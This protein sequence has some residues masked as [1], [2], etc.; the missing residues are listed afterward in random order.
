MDADAVRLEPPGAQDRRH[1]AEGHQVAVGE[2]GEAEHRVDQRDAERAERQL[3]AVGEPGDQHEV[4]QDHQ[5]VEGVLHGRQPPR[6]ARR[7][8]GSASSAAPVSV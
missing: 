4:R 5:G 6:K 1:R 7:T 3:R 2:I 8:S